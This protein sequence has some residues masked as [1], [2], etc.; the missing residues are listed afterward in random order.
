[1][2]LL[3]RL[4]SNSV[5]LGVAVSCV[6]VESQR[7]AVVRYMVA[8]NPLKSYTLATSLHSKEGGVR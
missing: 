5:I 1:M 3:Y 8:L 6:L 7:A 2:V 4:R